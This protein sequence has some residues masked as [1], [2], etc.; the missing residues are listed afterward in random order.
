MNLWA[1]ESTCYG[2]TSKGYL[3]NGVALPEKGK[4]FVVYSELAQS[5]GRTYVHSNVKEI[6]L[7]A[8]SR[9]EKSHPDKVYKYG[10]T[11]FIT[12]GQFRPHKTHL[13]R[14]RYHMPVSHQ[15]RGR[16]D[17]KIETENIPVNTSFNKIIM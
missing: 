4:N 7:G 1:I 5:L 6:I 11:G 3:R 13:R 15:G 14:G 12:G 8:Y 2:T 17:R 9:L 16:V 10:E